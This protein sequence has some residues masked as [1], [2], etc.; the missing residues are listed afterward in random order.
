[1]K[2]N[3]SDL[4]RALNLLDNVIIRSS[5]DDPMTTLVE[6]ITKDGILYGYGWDKTNYIRV[7]VTEV[8]EDFH[9]TLEFVL[10]FNI[11]KSI[12]SDVIDIS[13]DKKN[14]KIINIKA[15]EM[16]CKLNIIYDA[17][18]EITSIPTEPA[19]SDDMYQDIDLSKFNSY[20]S[21]IK[22]IIDEHFVEECYQNV[23]ISKSMLFTDLDNVILVNENLFN[24]NILLKS[25]SINILSKLDGKYAIAENSKHI[26]SLYVKTEDADLVMIGQDKE[27]YDK[28]ELLT[29]FS[30]DFENTC[31]IN[32]ELLSDAINTS[33][34]FSY[35]QLQLSFEQT[36]VYIKI[37][38][39]DFEYKISDDLCTPC[40]YEV[41]RT[42]L[43]RL[44]L[45]KDDVKVS[46]NKDD[47][48]IRVDYDN[49]HGIFSLRDDD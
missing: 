20:K 11:V 49:I 10:F 40:S 17:T 9:A 15:A 28:D 1:M 27:N 6:F 22:S 31:T 24:N 35:D 21:L 45:S 2:I 29:L 34:L 12:K 18:K 46:Y 39:I 7:K 36:G 5:L 43:K 44:I 30:V 33:N 16:K 14:Q 38:P 42:L 47:S 37:K 48:I 19:L 4:K 8:D 23:Y 13:V 41:D 26:L 3:V 32:G 25:K